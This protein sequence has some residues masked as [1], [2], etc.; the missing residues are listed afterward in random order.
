MHRLDYQSPLGILSLVREEENLIGAW[1]EGQAHYFQKIDPNNCTITTKD[2]PLFQPFTTFLDAY[3]AGQNP[4]ITEIYDYLTPNGTV[5]QQR[6]WRLLLH[7]P[8]GQTLAYMDI[9]NQYTQL[10]KSTSAR[11]V[12]GAVGKNPLSIFIPCHRVIAKNGQLTGYAGG[13]DRKTTLL[14]LEQ[15]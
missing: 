8:Y 3:F 12:G 4:S 1:F 6:I 9:A 15:A 13:L 14:R 2:D 11:A 5:Y 10:Q 7:I